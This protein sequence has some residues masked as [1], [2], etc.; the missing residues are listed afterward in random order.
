MN[1]DDLAFLA[2]PAGARLLDDLADADL[3]GDLLRHVTALRKTYTAAQVSAAI[4]QAELRRAAVPKFGAAASRLF[5]TADALQQASDPLIRAYR[6]DM[7]RGQRVVDLCCGIGADALAFA[8]TNPHVCGVDHDAERI[9]IARHNAA[10]LGFDHLRFTVDDVTRTHHDA[11][12]IFFDPARRDADGRRIHDVNAYIPPLHTIDRHQ[13]ARRL[14]KVS[15][16]V[17]LRQLAGRSCA[18]EFISVAGDLKEALLHIDEADG[19]RATRLESDGTRHHWDAGESPPPVVTAPPAAYLIEPDP[20]LIRAG[21]VR[22]LAAQIDGAL[23]D[24][25]IAYITADQ[26]P[27]SVWYRAWRVLD[28]MPFNLKKLRAYLRGQGVGAVT[29]KKRG[30]AITPEALTAGLKLKGEGSRT[31]VLTRYESRPIVMICADYTA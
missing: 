21:L 24:P 23:L 26:A 15:P 2:S 30:S 16:A 3:Q 8:A 4:T 7:I 17:D 29:V 20:A 14:V 6:A 19:L 13:A 10:A 9:T 11:D 1:S 18:V 31:L 27:D 25:T 12:V 28:W 5:F 22:H